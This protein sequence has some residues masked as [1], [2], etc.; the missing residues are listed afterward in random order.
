MITNI[1]AAFAQNLN[2]LIWMD[3]P[4]RNRAMEK[5]NHIMN[6]IGMCVC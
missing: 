5:L 1:E 6:K 3:A 4:T 2:T